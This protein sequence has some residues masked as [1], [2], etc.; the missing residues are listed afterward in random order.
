MILGF[1]KRFS[2][3]TETKFK[4]K[5]LRG[6]YEYQMEKCIFD[7]MYS[8]GITSIQRDNN[9]IPKIHTIRTD[10]H[11]RWKAG[12]EIHFC[13]GVRT[14]QMDNFA[15]GVCK[16]VQEV[17][18][19]FSKIN[20]MEMEIVIGHRRLTQEEIKTLAVNDGFN[21]VSDFVKYFRAE[22]KDGEYFQV[23]RGRLIHW[24]DLKY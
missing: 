12:M 18:F 6:I 1:M 15:M 17:T 14:K 4:E 11:Q 24:T 3:K 13:T 2:D 22:A 9:E 19:T 20:V 10:Q 23:Y 21:H 8:D 16:S 5:I 7:P